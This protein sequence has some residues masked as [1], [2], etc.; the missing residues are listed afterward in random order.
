VPVTFS[1]L[2]NYGA[3]N[4]LS[5]ARGWTKAFM[6]MIFGRQTMSRVRKRGDSHT[7]CRFP[8]PTTLLSSG[9][10]QLHRRARRA[11]PRRRLV[12]AYLNAAR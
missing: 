9:L 11:C 1:A 10:L 5:M 6:A 8:A 2:K 12:W 7:T 4:C 3:T